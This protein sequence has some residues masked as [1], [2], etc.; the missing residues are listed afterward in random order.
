MI[1]LNGFTRVDKARDEDQGRFDSS[2]PTIL[3]Q[4]QFFHMKPTIENANDDEFQI[5][6][7]TQSEFS[8]APR[9]IRDDG[10]A[11]YESATST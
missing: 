5:A 1:G 11:V 8:F 2:P 4:T 3:F 10:L 6:N 9:Y 7:L